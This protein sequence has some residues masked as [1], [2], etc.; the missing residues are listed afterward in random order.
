M[1]IAVSIMSGLGILFC[2]IGKNGLVNDFVD[3]LFNPQE[4]IKVY[5][6][7]ETY[8]LIH[9]FDVFGL[10]GEVNEDVSD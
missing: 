9:D 4:E 1:I 3:K 8:N 10:T 6:C 7:I 5:N 2:T